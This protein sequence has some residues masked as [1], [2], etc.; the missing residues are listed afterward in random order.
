M[1]QEFEVMLLKAVF[2]T[3]LL[4]DSLTYNQ[5]LIVGSFHVVGFLGA[6]T[7]HLVI[8]EWDQISSPSRI[9]SG[10]LIQIQ[11]KMAS[12]RKNETKLRSSSWRLEQAS[13]RNDT[14]KIRNVDHRYC[15]SI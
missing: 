8:Y 10:S 12:Q 9:L 6:L 2:Y 3:F 13:W 15:T 7:M 11:G 4:K 14:Y 5:K 1:L